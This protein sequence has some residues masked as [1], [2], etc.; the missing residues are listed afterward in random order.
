MRRRE[1]E[2][3][4]KGKV[5]MHAQDDNGGVEEVETSKRSWLRVY[6]RAPA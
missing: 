6:L 5:R 1:V 4:I 3:R 2:N